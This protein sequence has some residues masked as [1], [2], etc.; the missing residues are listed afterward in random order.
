VRSA[1][2]PSLAFASRL[3]ISVIPIAMLAW[4][5]SG[6]A[7]MA[8][9]PARGAAAAGSR[10]MAS[11][12]EPIQ[13]A[14]QPL[15]SLSMVSADFDGDGVA[16]LA[17]GS[18]NRAGGAITIEPGNLDAI[19]PQTEASWTAAGLHQATTPFL[20]ASQTIQLDSTPDLLLSA[21]V[22]GSGQHD[23][24]YATTGSGAIHVLHYRACRLSSRRAFCG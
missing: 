23:L 3:L 20:P 1:P 6:S 21:D 8:Q 5:F 16:D 7:L 2:A 17:I 24:V 9:L 12:R 10:Q 18:S 19:A 14:L 11:A 4:C 15:R 22:I 13:P